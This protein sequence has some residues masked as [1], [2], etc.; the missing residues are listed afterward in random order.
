MKGNI[1]EIFY[2]GTCDLLLR[3]LLWL[4]IITPFTVAILPPT[5]KGITEFRIGN[6]LNFIKDPRQL[7]ASIY[8]DAIDKKKNLQIS[9][10]KMS[11]RVFNG[12]KDSKIEPLKIYIPKDPAQL[13]IMISNLAK[14]KRRKKLLKSM[15]RKLQKAPASNADRVKIEITRNDYKMMKYKK[16]AEILSKPHHKVSI[17][18]ARLFKD[19]KTRKEFFKQIRP[20]ISKVDR[21]S[22]YTKL[23]MGLNI[24]LEK[25]LLPKFPRK[26]VGKYI[27]YR[28]PNCFHASLAFQGQRFTRSPNFNI[29]IE[30]GYH[31]AM[32][33]YDELWR[34][35]SL[36]FYEV[37][38]TKSKLKYGDLLIFFDLPPDL[39]S[40]D[41]VNFRWIR[42][43]STYLFGNYTFSKGSKSPSTPYSVKTVE[44][45]WKTWTS[46]SRNLGLK[47]FRRSQNKKRKPPFDLTDWIY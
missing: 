33:N 12:S 15:L 5:A 40:L 46:Y 29:K 18:A 17:L 14:P 3:I 34:T 41:K 1:Y 35:L 24:S 37:D 28:G 45:E 16:L 36:N 27:I 30:K 6:H 42:H 10:S 13:D 9:K 32:V 22:I 31:K 21:Y 47:V 23:K 26:M 25:E 38:P 43:A 2:L 4:V 19:V 20:Y 11:R 39:L 7:K 44:E 8:L